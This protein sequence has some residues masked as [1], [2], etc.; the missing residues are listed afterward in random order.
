MDSQSVKIVTDFAYKVIVF[1]GFRNTLILA[2]IAFSC[3][4]INMYLK[5]KKDKYYY[6][7][8]KRTLE[9][10]IR[11]LSDKVRAYEDKKLSTYDIA[12]E[13][14]EKMNAVQKDIKLKEESKND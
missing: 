13:I 2:I 1:I 3:Y 11:Q 10:N 6:N 14:L 9:Q 7:D 4:Q 8:M 5:D 12:P